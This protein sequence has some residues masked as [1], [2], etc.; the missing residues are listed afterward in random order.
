[1][2]FFSGLDSLFYY[3]IVVLHLHCYYLNRLSYGDVLISP[4]SGIAMSLK[5]ATEEHAKLL[6]TVIDFGLIT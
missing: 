1:M 3:L 4:V 5:N 6:G 2:L